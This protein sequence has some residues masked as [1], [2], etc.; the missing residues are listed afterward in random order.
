MRKLTQ[1]TIAL[2]TISFV[3][4]ILMGSPSAQMAHAGNGNPMP[5]VPHDTI[6]IHFQD[7]KDPGW[8]NNCDGGHALHIG[9]ERD[10]QTGE[11]THVPGV[12]IHFAMIDWVQIDNDQDGQFDEDGPDGVDNDGDGK[13][14]EDPKEPGNKTYAEDCDTR[15]DN[16]GEESVSMWIRDTEPEKNV[17]SIQQW[18]LRLVGQPQQAFVFTTFGQYTIS[19]TDIDPN[20]VDNDGD[21]SVSED[22]RNGFDDDGDGLVDED[23]IEFICNFS[24][25][26]PLAQYSLAD[27]TGDCIGSYKE[28]GKGKQG[29]TSFCDVTDA[30]QVDV[31]LDGDGFDT[32]QGDLDDAHIFTLSCEENAALAPRV[33]EDPVDGTDNDGDGLIDEDPVP[34]VDEDGDGLIDEDPI[35]G[36]DNDGD[37]LIDED[38]VGIDN[39]GDGLVDEDPIAGIDND[40]DGAIDE[41]EI[42]GLDNDGDGAIDEDSADDDGDGLV[43]EDDPNDDGD[44]FTSTDVC[45]LGK[46]IWEIDQKTG[47]PTVQLFLSHFDSDTVKPTKGNTKVHCNKHST[48]DECPQP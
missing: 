22:P 43:N 14:D 10:K 37:G 2:F 44:F 46:S 47:R 25:W 8:K 1:R 7:K 4:A 18:W 27:N 11:I 16:P 23:P 20:Q 48:G 19:C 35:D 45:P 24:E 3:V 41:D 26:I 9:I 30:V 29:K 28:K 21:G 15:G 5:G 33:N 39:D 31:D 12:Q 32:T 40:G 34:N 17:I 42:D 38:P 36:T 13:T 6:M